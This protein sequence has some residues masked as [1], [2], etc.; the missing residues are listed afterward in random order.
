M[1]SQMVYLPLRDRRAKALV[2]PIFRL[3][4]ETRGSG[5]PCCTYSRLPQFPPT[6]LALS[7]RDSLLLREIV[8]TLWTG[9]KILNQ[10]LLYLS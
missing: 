4:R 6:N 3:Y 2:R 5:I 8:E 10:A 7:L 1:E 9:G